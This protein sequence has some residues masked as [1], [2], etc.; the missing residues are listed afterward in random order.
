MK[1]FFSQEVV[2]VFSLNAIA[3]F[4]RMITGFINIKIIA[5]LIGPVGIALLGQ[6]NNFANIVLAWSSG[7]INNGITKY[8]AQ[9]S[10]SPKK[11][12]VYLKTSIWIVSILSIFFC[13]ILII[14]SKYFA[15][16][17]LK[18]TKYQS[19]F[20]VFG[21]SIIL[22]S[23]NNLLIS[24]LNGYKQYQQ[25]IKVNISGSII[26]VIFTVLL[27]YYFNLYGA[28]LAAITY[29]SIVFFVTLF[30][31]RNAIWMKKSKLIGRFSFLAAKNLGKYSIMALVSAIV[32]P[33]S[34]I[35]IRNLI[36]KF[37]S[38]ETAGIWEGINRISAMYLMVVTTS[39][40]VYYLPKLSELLGSGEIKNEIFKLYKIFLPFVLIANVLIYMVR[41]NIV[42]I[43]FSKEF[44][45]MKDYFFFQLLGD[46]FRI[47]SFLLAYLMIAKAMMNTYII[48]EIIF[49]LS[50][51]FLSYMA[52]L[53]YGGIG[54]T[55]GYSVN[56]FIYWLVM[57]IL[58][59]K[60][61]FGTLNENTISR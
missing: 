22:Y 56:Y 23:F 7:G 46:F 5:Y 2:K 33:S 12:T 30:L 52:V 48:T 50:Y 9:Y 37:N 29:Q 31:C 60:V 14:G 8:L 44:S 3:T 21:V 35:I 16:L 39:L 28:L 61:L 10:A 26:G 18:D 43:L 45:S 20:I 4:V 13:I 58:F 41:D 15:Y 32:V 11:T 47:G 40:S 27:T 19:I 17:I 36:I 34:Q 55:I 51:V 53:K 42:I 59:R 57:I 24:I 25:Y 49:S 6:L 54:A 1:K 38:L